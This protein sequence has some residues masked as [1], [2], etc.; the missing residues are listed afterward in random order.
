MALCAFMPSHSTR[1]AITTGPALLIAVGGW[2]RPAFQ[3]PSG[4]NQPNGLT[5]RG[6][7]WG[8]GAVDWLLA[9]NRTWLSH[10]AQRTAHSVRGMRVHVGHAN[11]LRAAM[12]F[13]FAVASVQIGCPVPHVN[14]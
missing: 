8:L 6:A 10:S 3:V 14:V 11:A 9:A 7:L 5:N 4:N 13:A 1:A 12:R 2:T